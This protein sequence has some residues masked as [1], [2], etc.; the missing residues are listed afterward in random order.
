MPALEQRRRV[1]IGDE[2]AGA[3]R[4]VSVKMRHRRLVVV[5]SYAGRDV[6]TGIVAHQSGDAVS[7]AASTATS[8]ALL[9]QKLQ[10]RL[11]MMLLRTDQ[12]HE[13]EVWMVS[14]RR[15]I[16]STQFIPRSTPFAE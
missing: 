11:V 15:L 5:M 1:H 8:D 14:L 10:R 3:G 7:V 13:D 16:S 9:R 4:K 12:S 6:L 2:S